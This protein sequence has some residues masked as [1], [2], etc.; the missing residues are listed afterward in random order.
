MSYNKIKGSLVLLA[1]AVIWGFAFVAQSVGMDY[2]GPFAFN[3][4]RNILGAIVLLPY[5]LWNNNRK[6]EQAADKEDVKTLILGGVCCGIFLCIAGNLQ[7]IGIV[8]T[9][10]GKAGFITTL[11]IILVP[12]FGVFLKKKI[13][14]KL[15]ISAVMGV[16]GLYLLCMTES[17]TLGKGD[18]YVLLCAVFFAFQILAVDYFAK[19]VDCVKLSAMQFFVAGILS[20]MLVGV[21]ENPS[22]EAICKAWLPI[23]YAGILSSGVAFTFQTI[24]QKILDNTTVASLIMSLESVVSALAGWFILKQALSG[25]EIAGCIVM[26]GAIILAQLPDKKN[27]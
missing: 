12:F 4:T 17:F 25:K 8:Y 3:A 26:F 5:I 14:I 2:V 10:V 11:Y 27:N 6:K 13:G 15:W 16:I 21:F 23:A 1:A 7:Q 22:W 19:Q 18:I 9:T 24:G 20:F